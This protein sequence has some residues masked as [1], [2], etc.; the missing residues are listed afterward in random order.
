M[1]EERNRGGREKNCKTN[2]DAFFEKH[3]C[4]LK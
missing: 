2:P 1:K 3:G 4:C